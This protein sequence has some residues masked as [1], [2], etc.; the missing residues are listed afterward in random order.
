MKTYVLPLAAALLVAAAGTANAGKIVFTAFAEG[1]QATV[2]DPKTKKTT[3]GAQ[4]EVA[5]QTEY[6]KFSAAK[7][8][9]YSETV[10]MC[11]QKYYLTKTQVSWKQKH[12]EAKHEIKVRDRVKAGTFEVVCPKEA[13]APPAEKKPASPGPAPTSPTD[14]KK[15]N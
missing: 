3:A 13:A 10:E 1:K 8:K 14:K 5:T 7:K 9:Q 15:T 4:I 6:D 2:K 11:G 12:E